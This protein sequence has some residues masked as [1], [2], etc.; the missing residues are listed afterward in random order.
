M[1]NGWIN[2][3]VSGSAE[4]CGPSVLA[5]LSWFL[6]MST[7]EMLT[8]IGAGDIHKLIGDGDGGGVLTDPFSP[9]YNFG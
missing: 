2:L 4:D 5:P 8:D 3:S 7:P 6:G 1:E 9:L